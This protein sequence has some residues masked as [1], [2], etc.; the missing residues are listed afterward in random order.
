MCKD[1]YEPNIFIHT[2]S[3]VFQ[4]MQVCKET[5]QRMFAHHTTPLDV[6]S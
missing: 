6:R 4:N 5:E 2:S 1:V 3:V